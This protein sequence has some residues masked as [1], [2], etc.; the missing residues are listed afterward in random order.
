MTDELEWREERSFVSLDG[1]GFVADL[2]WATAWDKSY[3]R[4]YS[5]KDGYA[6]SRPEHPLLGSFDGRLSTAKAAKK[7]CAED[8]A[9]V[10]RLHRWQEY[11]KTN[12]PPGLGNQ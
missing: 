9:M 5:W 4:V 3:Y 6:Y 11:M 12:E 8:F 2:P 1:T 7:E 10:A